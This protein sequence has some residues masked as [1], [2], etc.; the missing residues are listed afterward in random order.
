MSPTPRQLSQ[1]HRG[2]Q[3]GQSVDVHRSGGSRSRRP[4][5]PQ[6][7]SNRPAQR[8]RTSRATNEHVSKD[9][10]IRARDR[11]DMRAAHD[12]RA[13]SRQNITVNGERMHTLSSTP[14]GPF[15]S[16][17]FSSRDSTTVPYMSSDVSRYIVIESYALACAR[18]HTTRNSV[19]VLYVTKRK[20]SNRT[21]QR[22]H[23]H[24]LQDGREARAVA[25]INEQDRACHEAH[26]RQHRRRQATRQRHTV[27]ADAV[28]PSEH[29]DALPNGLLRASNVHLLS[30]RQLLVLLQH[31]LLGLLQ[32]LGLKA[33]SS[34]PN[35]L[36]V[37]VSV[38]GSPRRPWPGR[39]SFQPSCA[40]AQPS[41][42][43]S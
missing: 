21:H 32:T 19:R 43:P 15:S 40:R 1:W 26:H 30:L 2:R 41:S 24:A 14:P 9:C 22:A 4:T 27:L 35:P 31:D 18:V 12:H 36:A 6:P 39:R 28:G 13:R 10:K 34:S 37:I 23:Q 16:L 8:K 29:L 7:G 42:Q 38:L 3:L 17:V 5:C 20:E 11:S 33:S 25:Q